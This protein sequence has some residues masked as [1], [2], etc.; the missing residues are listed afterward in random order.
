M[1]EAKKNVAHIHSKYDINNFPFDSVNG[2]VGQKYKDRRFIRESLNEICDMYF[3][4]SRKAGWVPYIRADMH[5]VDRL[6]EREFP[7][8]EFFQIIG[9]VVSRSEKK[10]L[11][12]AEA[13]FEERLKFINGETVEAIVPLRIN[14]YGHG[15]WMVGVSISIH[16]DSATDSRSFHV[17]IRTCYAERNMVHRKREIGVEKIWTRGM[18]HW[19]KNP[20]PYRDPYAIDEEE[21]KEDVAG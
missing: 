11:D 20:E 1:T 12:Y 3:R 8:S 17:N 16:H 4:K 21:V 2:L 13:K 5:V 6:S 19:M 14:C 9:K 10:I 18:P 7:I 15:A